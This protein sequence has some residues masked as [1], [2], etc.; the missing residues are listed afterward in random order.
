VTHVNKFVAAV[1]IG[2]WYHLW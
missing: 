1:T 2:R